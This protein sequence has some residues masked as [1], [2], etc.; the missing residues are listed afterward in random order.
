MTLKLQGDFHGNTLMSREVDGFV[1]R[2]IMHQPGVKI[3]GSG[4]SQNGSSIAIVTMKKQAQTAVV[5][6]QRLQKG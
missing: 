4:S 2:E 5:H 3:P 6:H 1:L